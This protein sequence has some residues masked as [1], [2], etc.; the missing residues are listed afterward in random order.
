D[1]FKGDQLVVFGT[2]EKGASGAVTL[3]GTANGK[4]QKFS[5]DV[6]FEEK[7]DASKEWI[8]KLWATRRI[9]YLL[10]EIRLHGESKEVKDEVV[11]LARQWGV[12]TP[13]TAMLIIE[14]ERRRHVPV[15]QRSLREMETEATVVNNAERRMDSLRASEKAGAS[16]VTDSMN[17]KAY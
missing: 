6:T 8:G 1:L 3:T 5:Q 15:A 16:A 9:G 2:Y 17:A 14:D 12:V 13:Y 7:T 4:E 10:D 11:S